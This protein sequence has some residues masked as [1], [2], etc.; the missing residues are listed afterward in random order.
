MGFEREKM[1]K[2]I[3]QI[4]GYKIF[5]YQTKLNLAKICKYITEIHLS[6]GQNLIKER[7]KVMPKFLFY[8]EG[9]KSYFL[10]KKASMKF[11]R[12]LKSLKLIHLR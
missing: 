7:E 9:F 4:S 10:S 11:Q 12:I 6:K 8:S 2:Q 1:M 5:S 3:K